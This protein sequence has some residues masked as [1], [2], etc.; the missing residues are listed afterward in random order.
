MDKTAS[1]LIST[2]LYK[3]F[4]SLLGSSK[5]TSDLNFSTNGTVTLEGTLVNSSSGIVSPV[6]GLKLGSPDMDLGVWNLETAPSYRTRSTADLIKTD[7]TAYPQNEL[8]FFYQ[9]QREVSNV[10]VVYNPRVANTFTVT[11]TPVIYKKYNNDTQ[12]FGSYPDMGYI[13][14]RWTIE[15]VLY[16]D[17][18][19]DITACSSNMTFLARSDLWPNRKYEVQGISKVAVYLVGNPYKVSDNVALKILVNGRTTVNGTST[20][21]YSCKTFVPKQMYY[22]DSA[23]PYSWSIEELRKYGFL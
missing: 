21:F 1:G 4:G 14:D 9:V 20:T 11:A 13:S 2:G 6:A 19:T 23:R 5:T 7:Y 18:L 15:T 22:Y 17:S 12:P 16:T 3:V 10:Q 8:V